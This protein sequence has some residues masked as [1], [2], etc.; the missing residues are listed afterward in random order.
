MMRC[1][2]DGKIEE[3]LE[4]GTYAKLRG[5]PTAAQENSWS[6]KL[7]G[8]EKNQEITSAFCKKLRPTGSQP[9]GLMACPKSTSLMCHLDLLFRA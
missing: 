1:D 7:K 9:L 6:R 4:T 8:L 3:M 2:Y 5:D